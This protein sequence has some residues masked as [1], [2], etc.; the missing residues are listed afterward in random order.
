MIFKWKKSY[1]FFFYG[2]GKININGIKPL[3]YD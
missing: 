3:T 1:G 2:I